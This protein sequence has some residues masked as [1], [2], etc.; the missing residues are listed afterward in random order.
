MLLIKPTYCPE[1]FNTS[2]ELKNS[3]KVYLY[4]DGKKKESS[5]FL[6]NIEK[7]SAEEIHQRLEEKLEDF[8]KWYGSFD[9][10]LTINKVEAISPDFVCDE[11]CTLAAGFQPSV[12][13]VLFE[14]S[15]FQELV[16]ETA[17]KYGVDLD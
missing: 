4:F 5:V 15:V 17:T 8:F 10:K 14:E 16:E 2:L 11:G 1:C 13:G 7:D 3:G 12:G 9:N 6:Y